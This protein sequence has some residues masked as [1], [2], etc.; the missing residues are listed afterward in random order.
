MFFFSP[1]W[2]HRNFPV[3][4]QEFAARFLPRVV[5]IEAAANGGGVGEGRER[6]HS[7][8][9][10]QSPRCRSTFIFHPVFGYCAQFVK[11]LTVNGGPILRRIAD[12]A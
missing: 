10:V 6:P 12:T 1:E 9:A 4:F 7:G 2:L 8:F 3:L 11:V 5:V